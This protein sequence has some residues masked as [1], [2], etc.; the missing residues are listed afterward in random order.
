M[1]LA[2]ARA[3]GSV[4]DAAQRLGITVRQ[5]R[6][7]AKRYGLRPLDGRASNGGHPGT[8]EHQTRSYLRRT[9]AP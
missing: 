4:A 8:V 6:H 9:V 5:M 3:D 1:R 7:G 2:L